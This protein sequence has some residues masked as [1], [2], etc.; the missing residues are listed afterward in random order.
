MNRSLAATLAIV[1]FLGFSFWTSPSVGQGKEGKGVG[2]DQKTWDAVVNKAIRFLKAT[3]DKDGGWNT[4][5]SPGITGI[6][7]TGMLKTG[8]VKVGETTGLTFEHTDEDHR[9]IRDA[10]REV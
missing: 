7:L 3:Q 9:S 4:A 10:T 2:P 8:K 5:K 1:C 6:A